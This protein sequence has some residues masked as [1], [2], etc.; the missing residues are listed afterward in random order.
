MGRQFVREGFRSIDSGPVSD[1]VPTGFEN[2]G[3]SPPGFMSDHSVIG[4]DT[5]AP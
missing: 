3:H 1:I 5:I 2:L 4:S